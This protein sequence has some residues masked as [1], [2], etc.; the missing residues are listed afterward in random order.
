M[1]D[2]KVQRRR[3]DG[4]REWRGVRWGKMER[5]RMGEDENWRAREP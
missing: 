3:D 1:G 5:M 2:G 4:I